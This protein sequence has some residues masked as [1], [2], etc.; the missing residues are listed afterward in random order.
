MGASRTLIRHLSD[1]LISLVLPGSILGG[2]KPGGNTQQMHAAHAN[3]QGRQQRHCQDD[4]LQYL[5]LQ[6]PDIQSDEARIW[7]RLMT[8]SPAPSDRNHMHTR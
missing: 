3:G 7:K 5:D 4:A 1:G 2:L 8:A 6:D